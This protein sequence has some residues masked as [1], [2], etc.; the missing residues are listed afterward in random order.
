MSITEE[1]PAPG[2]G[3]ARGRRPGGA[4]DVSLHVKREVVTPREAAVAVAAFEGLGARVLPVVAGQFVAAG[5]APAAAFP[6]ALVRLLSCNKRHRISDWARG[7]RGQQRLPLEAAPE[8]TAVPLHVTS[9]ITPIPIFKSR[10]PS[11]EI[12]IIQNHRFTA[13]VNEKIPSDFS[14][15]IFDINK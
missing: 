9:P 8:G 10:P 13:H 12:F 15:Q 2:V 1:G 11:F 14:E 7:T 3:S 4:L 5:E 6:L